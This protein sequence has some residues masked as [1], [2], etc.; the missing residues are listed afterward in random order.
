MTETSEKFFLLFSDKDNGHRVKIRY[1]VLQSIMKISPSTSLND[2][3]PLQKHTFLKE[4]EKFCGISDETIDEMF[5]LIVE[6][7]F[8]G[9]GSSMKLKGDLIPVKGGRSV[10]PPWHQIPIYTNGVKGPCYYEQLQ[11]KLE[12]E[13]KEKEMEVSENNENI[14]HIN[15]LIND[16]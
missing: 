5:N 1:I 6:D 16:P 2:L 9:Q 10:A 7:M 15:L 11:E 3:G 8:D 14:K 12:K 4:A 13:E